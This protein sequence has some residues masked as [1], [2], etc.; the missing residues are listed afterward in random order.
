MALHF[1]RDRQFLPGGIH[2]GRPAKD[3]THRRIGIEASLNPLIEAWPYGVVPVKKMHD[4]SLGTREAGMKIADMA[5]VPRLSD[6]GD[7]ASANFRHDTLWIV[8][9][10]VVHHL[11]LHLLRARSLHQHAS[12][13]L[14][15]KARTIVGGD[16][17]RPL[18]TDCLRR[19]RRDRIAMLSMQ[20]C[21]HL[22]DTE[23]SSTLSPNLTMSRRRE[24]RP[25]PPDRRQRSK[26][27]LAPATSPSAKY[28]FDHSKK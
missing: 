21:L 15:K 19:K 4:F 22:R 11:D 23:D 8:G 28:R 20:G 26:Q 12:Q 13:R 6:K 24:P 7:A 16:H 25:K 17:H 5:N 14:A 27:D 1:A 10:T 3:G 2:E 18:R 9:G